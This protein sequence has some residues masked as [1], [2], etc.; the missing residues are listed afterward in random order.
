MVRLSEF[1]AAD[2]TAATISRLEREGALVRLARGLYQLPNASID[3]HHTLA[4][5]AK[6]VPKGVICLASALA[7]HGLTDQ[8]PP[9]IWIAINSKDWRP[10]LQYPPMRFVRFS[11]TQLNPLVE[12][13]AIDG[14]RVPI[15]GIAKTIADLFRYRRT[16]GI[17]LAVE[18]LREALR[19]RKATPAKIAKCAHDAGVWK[20][21]EPYLT[22]YTSGG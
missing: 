1:M 11:D 19:Q 15:F 17:N 5:A 3:A 13:H 18:G 9:K 10:R 16:V 6:L 14:I 7:F 8:L 12:Y 21:V 22:A 2:I 4:D 20:I